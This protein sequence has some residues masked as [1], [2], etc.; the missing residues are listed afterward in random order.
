MFKVRTKEQGLFNLTKKVLDD[1][2]LEVEKGLTR[3]QAAEINKHH[4]IRIKMFDGIRLYIANSMGCFFPRFCWR[5]V[6][7]FQQIYE[8]TNDKIDGELNIVKIIRNLKDIKILMKYSLLTPELKH[9]IRH[10]EKYL[11]DIDKNEEADQDDV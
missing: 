6:N 10:S 8:E 4:E 2:D 5:N 11:I 9:Q 7:K 1:K 3:K